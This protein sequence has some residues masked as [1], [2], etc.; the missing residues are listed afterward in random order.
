MNISNFLLNKKR[1]RSPILLIDASVLIYQSFYAMGHLSYGGKETGVI[2]GFLKNILSL[3][4]RFNTSQFLFCWDSGASHRRDAYP[5]YKKKRRKKREDALEDQIAYRSLL[6]QK[7]ELEQNILP[8]LGFN[9]SFLMKGYEGDDLLA[10]WALRLKSY[11]LIV[12]TDA[13]MYQCL[14]TCDIWNPRKKALFTKKHFLKEFGID[15]SRW[16]MAKAIGGCSGDGVMGIE[17]VSDP[18][19]PKSKALK[20]IQDKLSKGA[21]LDKIQN[22]EGQAII[23]RNLPLVTVPYKHNN[24]PIRRM[25]LR[26]NAFTEDNFLLIFDRLHFASFLEKNYFKKWTQAFL[27]RKK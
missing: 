12:T 5:D 4:I 20:Y 27:E 19:N 22:E 21:T 9:N 24:M 7:Q 10:Y 26:R 17:G 13:D 14:N 23:K 6:N 18:K 25:I 3:A 15:P 16:A 8:T 11:S 1:P 2:Y